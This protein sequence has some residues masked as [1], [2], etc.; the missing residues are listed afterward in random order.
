[1]TI[2][3]IPGI[4]TSTNLQYIFKKLNPYEKCTSKP[5]AQF[6]FVTKLTQRKYVTRRRQTTNFVSLAN[7]GLVRDSCPLDLKQ[8]RIQQKREDF[9]TAYAGSY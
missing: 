8:S 2:F 5:I 7:F 1:M 9:T 6:S 4:L 3:F